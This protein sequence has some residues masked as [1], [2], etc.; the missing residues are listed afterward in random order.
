M[1]FH[2]IQTLLQIVNVIDNRSNCSTSKLYISSA[3]TILFKDDSEIACSS[4][5]SSGECW[6]PFLR[7]T[8]MGNI[9]AASSELSSSCSNLHKYYFLGPVLGY[10]PETVHISLIPFPFSFFFF[11]EGGGGNLIL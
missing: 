2:I 4:L 3:P 8:T 5:L 7:F 10:S 1:T 6:Q 9:D 11:K